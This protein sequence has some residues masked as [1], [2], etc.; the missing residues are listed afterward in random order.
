TTNCNHTCA[1][2]STIDRTITP[3]QGVNERPHSVWFAPAKF[4]KNSTFFE[5]LDNF[6]HQGINQGL[7]A[8][9]Q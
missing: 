3:R 6:L 2:M 9:T 7:T 5:N 1:T 8:Y 4:I